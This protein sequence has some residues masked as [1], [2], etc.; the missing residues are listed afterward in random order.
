VAHHAAG[1]AARQFGHVGVLLLRHDRAAGGEAVGDLD[2]AEVLAHPQ[3][4]L[5]GQAA[6]VHHGQRGG[7]AEL[8]G[9]VA[10]AHRV[11]AVLAHAV[12]AQGARHAL[13]VQRVAGAGQRG[14]AQRQA[15]DARRTSA[16]RS[17][18]RLNIST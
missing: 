14:G 2:E 13:A 17:A 7:G 12:H 1:L 10:V 18:S 4:Q 16:M 8:D 9:E 11:Q 5:F 6:D 15:V 3:D